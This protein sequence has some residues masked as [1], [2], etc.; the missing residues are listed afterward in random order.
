M[1]RRQGFAVAVGANCVHLH[2]PANEKHGVKKE[3]EIKGKERESAKGKRERDRSRHSAS[4]GDGNREEEKVEGR[5]CGRS[6][7][8][9]NF[10]V[11]H[12][13][14]L[15]VAIPDP[16]GLEWEMADI[17]PSPDRLK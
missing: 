10:T 11:L 13:L 15:S 8:R 2:L 17:S 5:G 3:D 6:F 12:R 1:D 7:Q 4:V 16:T 14:R 9:F